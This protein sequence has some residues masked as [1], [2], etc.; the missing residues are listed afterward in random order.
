MSRARRR[1]MQRREFWADFLLGCVMLFAL[2]GAC[3]VALR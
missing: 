2:A 3:W 1:A